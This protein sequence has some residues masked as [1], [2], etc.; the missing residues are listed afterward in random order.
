MKKLRP[1]KWTDG[2]EDRAEVTWIL[3]VNVLQLFPAFSSRCLRHSRCLNAP[4]LTGVGAGSWQGRADK[5]PAFAPCVVSVTVALL[6]MLHL[7]SA[8]SFCFQVQ[9]QKHTRQRLERAG[10]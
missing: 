2:G 4:Y 1:V 9:L 8:N 7:T 5:G 10:M 6:L 3:R